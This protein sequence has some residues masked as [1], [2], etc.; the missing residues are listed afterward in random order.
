MVVL[1]IRKERKT[2]SI[3]R[4][5]I[6]E[7]GVGVFCAWVVQYEALIAHWNNGP[8]GSDPIQ[9]NTVVDRQSDYFDMF[10]NMIVQSN[11]ELANTRIS[12]ATLPLQWITRRVVSPSLKIVYKI[13]C[14]DG[15]P[16]FI[17]MWL[18]ACAFSTINSASHYL[19]YII[20]FYLFFFL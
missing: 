14:G 15:C 10:G 11:H 13:I 2:Q 17:Q 18:H 5:C 16:L 6:Y 19:Y 1:F 7:A 8:R 4:S 12:T 9:R 20:C 3:V